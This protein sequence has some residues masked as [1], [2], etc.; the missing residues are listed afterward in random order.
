MARAE[1]FPI[2]V[3]ARMRHGILWEARAI[4][5]S[6]TKLAQLL[7]VQINLI[8]TW[9]NFK[10]CP[11]R[12]WWNEKGLEI[13]G[14]LSALLGRE[15][16]YDDLFPPQIRSTA[17]AQFPKIQERTVEVPYAQLSE[18]REQLALP[19]AQETEDKRRD[20]ESA[21]HLLTPSQEKVINMRFGFDGPEM[22]YDEIG[23]ELGVTRERVRQIETAALRKL[24]GEA[25]RGKNRPPKSLIKG[26]RLYAQ[27]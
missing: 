25:G 9:L 8:S 19:P 20:I 27:P 11:S 5:G 23:N 1:T 22:T 13:E 6:S 7:G 17:F 15:I 21:L 2:T 3:T 24:R 16:T 12:D 4:V 10:R 26:L 18:M 14:K